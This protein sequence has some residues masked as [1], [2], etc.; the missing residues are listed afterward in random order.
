MVMEPVFELEGRVWIL[1]PREFFRVLQECVAVGVVDGDGVVDQRVVEQDP[2]VVDALVERV[3]IPLGL[4][5]R[6][7]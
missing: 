4:W 7:R 1:Q 2:G 3:G 5:H 6:E